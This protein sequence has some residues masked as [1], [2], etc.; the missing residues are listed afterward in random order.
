MRG[1]G[2][3]TPSY[4]MSPPPLNV[5]NLP[6]CFNPGGPLRR[7][8]WKG[9][10]RDSNVGIST[11]TFPTLA[12]QRTPGVGKVGEV[13]NVEGG[14]VIGKEGRVPP[15]AKMV[16]IVLCTPSLEKREKTLK[17]LLSAVIW[18][19]LLSNKS[20]IFYR[21]Q[22]SETLIVHIGVFGASKRFQFKSSLL[23]FE[24]I[25]ISLQL[26]TVFGSC[27]QNPLFLM[28]AFPS[29]GFILFV[30]F[31]TSCCC[32][33]LINKVVVFWFL[34]LLFWVSLVL[35][36]VICWIVFWL[37]FGSI[38]LRFRGGHLT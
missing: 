37:V 22:K 15:R 2:P 32:C 31:F 12:S 23:M 30:F 35:L 38:F 34:F 36:C 6:N 24:K 33:C 3:H 28:L 26:F 10:G 14:G 18:V 25:N 11:P 4:S 20:Q 8:S 7:Q 17:P 16:H 1:G 29:V 9:W 5:G 13:S 19:L 21:K 27:F